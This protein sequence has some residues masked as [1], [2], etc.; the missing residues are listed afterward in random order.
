MRSNLSLASCLACAFGVALFLPPLP[1]RAAAPFPSAKTFLEKNCADCHDEVMKEAG[2]DLTSLSYDPENKASFA[3]WVK[4]H[5]RVMA[6]EMPPKK[7]KS[8]PDPKELEAF[9]KGLAATL[10]ASEQLIIAR[11][12][13]AMRAA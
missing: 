2:L 9:V 1:S 10:T 12:G 7:K 3:T 13:R 4:V 11:D 8:R 6:G 5:D